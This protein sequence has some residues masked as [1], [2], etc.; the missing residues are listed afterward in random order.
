MTGGLPWLFSLVRKRSPVL[1]VSNARVCEG[2][3][4]FNW[5][6]F[7]I[8]VPTRIASENLNRDNGL[9]SGRRDKRRDLTKKKSRMEY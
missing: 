4:S 3:R 7:L 6:K 2:S 8:Y 5:H 1:M 9:L